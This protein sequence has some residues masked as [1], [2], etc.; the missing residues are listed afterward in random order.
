[1]HS[2]SLK[3]KTGHVYTHLHGGKEEC[4]FSELVE[5]QLLATLN[6]EVLEVACF[7]ADSMF[8][9][10]SSTCSGQGPPSTT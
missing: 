3:K 5:Y 1:M 2:S 6:W 8:Q 4:G 9:F 7:Y 10:S